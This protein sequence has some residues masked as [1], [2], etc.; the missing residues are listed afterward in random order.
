MDKDGDL[1]VVAGYDVSLSG[2]KKGIF[3]WKNLGAGRSWKKIVIDGSSGA[4]SPQAGDIDKDGD[5]DVFG[6]SRHSNDGRVYLYTNMHTSNSGDP[7]AT[8]KPTP[9]PTPKSTPKPTAKPTPSR[10]PNQ[11]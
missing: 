9:K 5:P 6:P 4:Y 7:K 3:Y 11:K 2:G 1:D 8:P 10:L